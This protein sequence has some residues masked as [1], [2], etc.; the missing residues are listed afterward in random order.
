MGFLQISN[1]SSLL[2]NNWK[3]E[4]LFPIITSKRNQLFILYFVSEEGCKFLSKPW[5]ERPSLLRLNLLILLKM[6][7]QRSRTRRVS[8]QTN[9]VSSSQENNWKMEE[10]SP[11]ITSKRSRPFILS[12]G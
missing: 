3:M 8:H 5:L 11:I 4:E 12:L 10:H 6:S 2:A 1:V 9:S 7:R